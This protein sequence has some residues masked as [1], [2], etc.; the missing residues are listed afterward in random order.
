MQISLFLIDILIICFSWLVSCAFFSPDLSLTGILA[1]SQVA[2]PLILL[3]K[4]FFFTHQGLHRAILRY[5]GFP[6]AKNI[7]KAVVAGSLSAYAVINYPPFRWPLGLLT[8]DFLLTLSLVGFSRFFP[9]LYTERKRLDA[10]SGKKVLIYGAGDLGDAVARTLLKQDEQYVP[11]G[12]I[13]DDPRKIGRKVHNLPVLGNRDSL[14]RILKNYKMN[15][16]IIAISDASAEWLRETIKECRTYNVFCRIAPKISDMMNHDIYIKNIE[17]VD[18][19][20]RN[21][22]DLDEKQIDRFLRRKKILITG[23]AGSIG[24]ELVRQALRFRPKKLI[25]ADNSEFGLYKLEQEIQDQVVAMKDYCRFKFQLLDLCHTD[26]V[27]RV[28]TAEKPDIIIHAAAYKHVPLIEA[29]PFA[30]VTNN[31]QSSINIANAAHA[32]NVEKLVLISTDKAVRPTNIMGA[33]KRICELY[34]QNLN[35][36]SQ[37]EYVAVRFGNVLG[38]S[39]SVIPKFLEQIKNGGP[40]TVTHPEVTRYFMLTQEA[41]ELAMQAASIGHGGE[42]FILNMG[43]PVKIKDMAENL[44]FLSGKEPYKDIDIQF[45]GLRPGEKLYEELLIDETEKKTQYENITVGKMTFIDWDELNSKIN[46]LFKVAESEDR[47]AVLLGIKALVP[48]F[49]HLD[50]PKETVDSNVLPLPAA[51]RI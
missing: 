37:T 28:V 31:I 29:N 5:A 13:D 21:P 30:G 19:L 1:K 39:G 14:G 7:L 41:A 3:L 44:I 32:N 15:E 34:I 20:K 35:L 8:M 36:R 18:L 27:H 6:F 46:H 38:S 16:L 50:L 12:F 2:L 9:R 33:T 43:K 23:A 48:E 51:R 47:E 42:I 17:I 49:H 22:E 26:N 40:V 11:V 45:T 25:L 4:M 24:S 10:G